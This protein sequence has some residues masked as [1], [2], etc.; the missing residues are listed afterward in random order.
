MQWVVIE[1]EACR[2]KI[3]VKVLQ[4]LY[5]D[6]FIR[7]IVEGL[8]DIACGRVGDLDELLEKYGV[9]KPNSGGR[10]APADR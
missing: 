8:E 9:E 10:R 7:E 5:R 3:E 1:R 6:E 2:E 4:G